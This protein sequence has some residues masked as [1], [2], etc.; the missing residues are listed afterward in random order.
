MVGSPMRAM[1]LEPSRIAV[2]SLGKYVADCP[3]PFAKHRESY[4]RQNQGFLTSLRVRSTAADFRNLLAVIL[5][6]MHQGRR[7]FYAL[8][9]NELREYADTISLNNL[10]QTAC[11]RRYSLCNSRRP[12]S[13]IDVPVT[14]GEAETLLRQSFLLRVDDLMQLLCTAPSSIDKQKWM[15]ELTQAAALGSVSINVQST[16]PAIA[17]TPP[18]NPSALAA[19]IDAFKGRRRPTTI[20]RK[21]SSIVVPKPKPD[22]TLQVEYRIS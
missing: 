14:S 18:T 6:R 10:A 4:Q 20:D 17:A 15:I 13:V 19:V 3:S 16:R 7:F 21:R 22:D 1:R 12:C 2:N 5:P 11:L 8:V 9:D